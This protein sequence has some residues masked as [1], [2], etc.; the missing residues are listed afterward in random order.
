MSNSFYGKE[1]T[2]LAD[3][4][5][6]ELPGI[7]NWSIEGQ[8]RRMARDGQRF[9][10]PSSGREL[11][12][13]MEELGNPIGSFVTD[14]LEYDLEGFAQ[15]DDVFACWR[16]WSTAKNIPPGNDLTFKRRF[17]AATQDHRVV[18]ERARVD[19]ELCNIY[20]GVKLN[21]KAQKYIDGISQFEKEEI[22][23]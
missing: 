11:L 23:A 15:K 7:F 5:A 14:A 22:F 13:L 17:L 21:A 8:Q 1:D 3:R 9:K 12:E 20:R 18:A 16:R 10:Q 19:G 2:Q 4:L 6:K